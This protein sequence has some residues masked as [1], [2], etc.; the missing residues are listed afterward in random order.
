MRLVLHA[1][2]H[3]TG[4]S[5]IQRIL[6]D[7]RDELR[8]QGLYYPDPE[9]W[10]GK[11]PPAH[12]LLSHA[13]ARLDGPEL[14]TAH[15][16]LD[17]VAKSTSGRETVL[18]SAEPVYR[19][20]LANGEGP[21]WDRHEAYLRE[22]QDLL[23]QHGF[24]TDILLVF[25]RRDRLLESVYHER[26]ANGFD[27]P[28]SWLVEDAAHRFADYDRQVEVFSAIFPGDVTTHAYEEL[29]SEGLVSAFLGRLGA[30][31]DDLDESRWERPSTDGRLSL[32]MTARH[33]ENSDEKLANLRRRFSKHPDTHDLFEDFGRVTL[34][35][36]ED[37]RRALLDE[38]GDHDPIEDSR[39]PAVLSPDV[40]FVIDAAFDRYLADKGHPP[41]NRAVPVE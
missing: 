10:F 29:A 24:E 35:T 7:R 20:V 17:A 23:G 26:A 3:K 4:T 19:H 6:Y 27:R 38:Y 21:W 12:H 25:R 1:G 34:W 9:P 16:F 22:L 14:L 8:E 37:A 13:V 15:R 31:L 33:R 30:K 36:D 41:T 28:F 11:G 40:E 2:T 5:T 32:W 18:M 39:A